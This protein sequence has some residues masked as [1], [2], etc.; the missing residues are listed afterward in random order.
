VSSSLPCATRRTTFFAIAIAC[1][2]ITPQRPALAFEPYVI[3]TPASETPERQSQS[4]DKP[5]YVPW[6]IGT[7]PK[8]NPTDQI[9]AAEPA[10]TETPIS[11]VSENFTLGNQTNCTLNVLTDLGWKVADR[12]DPGFENTDSCNS[13][14]P[15]LFK[16]NSSVEDPEKLLWRAQLTLDGLTTKCSFARQYKESLTTAVNKL[17]RNSK[18]EFLP[19]G[20]DPRDPFLPPKEFWIATNGYDQPKN[21]ITESIQSL[22][23]N[24]VKAECS[25]AIQV[26]HLAGFSERYG[27]TF[28]DMVKVEEVGIGTWNQYAKTASV[29]AKQSFLVDASDRADDAFAK[30]A[31]IGT[32]A[33]FG[34]LGY[35]KPI[36]NKTFI[37]SLDNLGQNYLIVDITEA[38]VDSLKARERPIKELARINKDIWKKYRTK[39]R[40]GDAIDK[41][42]KEMQKELE[43]K[44][45]FYTDVKVY[46]HPLGVNTFAY[47]LARQFEYNPRTPYR[48]EPYEDYQQG[49]MFNRYKQHSLQQCLS[50][51]VP[52][53]YVP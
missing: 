7:P 33:F 11:V 37:D 40:A 19:A 13:D 49:F 18:F 44:D 51:N 20:N 28:A 36:K 24:E 27:S 52:E 3:G 9:K 14:V 42:R 43:T 50:G 15:P 53:R 45:L 2:S 17:W 21:S 38:A 25:A 26:A 30:L 12:R 23:K 39:L 5:D 8:D 47:H 6:I 48:F 31:N 4:D 10:T 35:I 16:Y 22:Y 29:S 32:A 1:T 46:V 41:L 34:Q